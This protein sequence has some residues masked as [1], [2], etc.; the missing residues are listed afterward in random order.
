MHVEY[1]IHKCSLVCG[2]LKALSVHLVDSI[3]DCTLLLDER[4]LVLMFPDRRLQLGVDLLLLPFNHLS[5][6][7]V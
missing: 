5:L 1:E 3:D 4:V 7:M 6:T 2:L